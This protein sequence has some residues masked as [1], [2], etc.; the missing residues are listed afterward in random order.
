MTTAVDPALIG[1]GVA[2]VGTIV[3]DGSVANQLDR[4]RERLEQQR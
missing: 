3:Y 1:G 4:I 2:R